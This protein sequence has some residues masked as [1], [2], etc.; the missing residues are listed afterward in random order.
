[1]L[2]SLGTVAVGLVSGSGRG[3]SRC[4]G[5]S[6]LISSLG[7][8]AGGFRWKRLSVDFVGSSRWW[9]LLEAVCGALVCSNPGM[10]I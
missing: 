8:V 9:I 4:L 5:R 10:V 3:C 6:L 2:S 1:M 7:A